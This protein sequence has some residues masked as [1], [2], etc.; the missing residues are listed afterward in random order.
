MHDFA[1]CIWLAVTME[2]K[3]ELRVFVSRVVRRE[4]VQGY[5]GKLRNKELH[6]LYSSSNIV[7]KVNRTSGAS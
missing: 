2:E 5:C 1:C 4:Y 7:R 6:D 3:C